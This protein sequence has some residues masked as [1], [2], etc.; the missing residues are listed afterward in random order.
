MNRAILESF[1][2]LNSGSDMFAMKAVAK[3]FHKLLNTL[4]LV[5][6]WF[7]GFFPGPHGLLFKTSVTVEGLWVT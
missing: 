1:A 5:R 3:L 7:R 4:S 6:Q 2:I